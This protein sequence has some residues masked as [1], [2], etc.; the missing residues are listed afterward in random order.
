MPTAQGYFDDNNSN[1]STHQSQTTITNNNPQPLD[2][3]LMDQCTFFTHALLCHGLHEALS[4]HLQGGEQQP[5]HGAGKVGRA[6]VCAGEGE[7][8]LG[9]ALRQRWGCVG[10]AGKTE[11]HVSVKE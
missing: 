9:L 5:L 7:G 3:A 6:A 8:F 1:S 2:V 4:V 10:G 11:Q